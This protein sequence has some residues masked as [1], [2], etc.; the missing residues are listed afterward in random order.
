MSCGW[1]LRAALETIR[2]EDLPKFLRNLGKDSPLGF[3]TDDPTDN[4]IY[5][6]EMKA[7]D[8]PDH[9]GFLHYYEVLWPLAHRLIGT[10][11]PENENQVRLVNSTIHVGRSQ[12]AAPRFC[13]H[14][15]RVSNRQVIRKMV[16][17]KFPK[18]LRLAEPTAQFYEAL[19]ANAIQRI[20]RGHRVRRK[21]KRKLAQMVRD[22]LS[23]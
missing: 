18:I 8:I 9:H 21:A 13:S 22:P 3:E 19:A 14:P 1:G 16:N 4:W 15:S 12:P 6:E 11:L 20:W 17:R 23:F 10:D 5:S 7:M 2:T